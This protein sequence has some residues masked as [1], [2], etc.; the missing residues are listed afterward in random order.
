MERQVA[1]SEDVATVVHALEEQYDALVSSLGRTSL[2]ADP[3]KLPTAD[4][5]GAELERYLAEQRPPDEG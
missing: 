2:L 4:E 5:I 1:G 3:A